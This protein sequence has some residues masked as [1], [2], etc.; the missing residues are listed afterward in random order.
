MPPSSYPLK[1]H[2]DDEDKEGLV[3]VAILKNDMRCFVAVFVAIILSEHPVS[4]SSVVVWV[5]YLLVCFSYGDCIFYPIS[6]PPF[7]FLHL[8]N[9]LRLSKTLCQENNR[10]G[11]NNSQ[12]PQCDI[13]QVLKIFT[14]TRRRGKLK[15][16]QSIQKTNRG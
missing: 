4:G 15:C 11:R 7:S 2:V 3:L 8:L 10:K 12:S 5:Q 9:S 1:S 14:C 16:V 13:R 6:Y